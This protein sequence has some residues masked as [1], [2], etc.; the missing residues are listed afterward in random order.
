[1]FVLRHALTRRNMMNIHTPKI[2]PVRLAS[3]TIQGVDRIGEAAAEE[4]DSAAAEITRGAAEIAEKLSELAEAIRGHSRI[5]HEQIAAFCDKATF[6]LD[7]LPNLR[8]RIDGVTRLEGPEKFAA[9]AVAKMRPM[10][11]VGQ[12]PELQAGQDDIP[13]FLKQGPAE[14][15]TQESRG[16]AWKE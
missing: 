11:T 16:I 13:G 8:E 3:A 9:V 4:I 2:S 15:E 7:A 1:M 5:A 10:K 14:F 12:E 6:L